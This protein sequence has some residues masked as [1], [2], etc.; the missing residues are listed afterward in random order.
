MG[1]LPLKLGEW[2][3]DPKTLYNECKLCGAR[4]DVMMREWNWD[5]KNK[6]W[7]PRKRHLPDCKHFA[8][9]RDKTPE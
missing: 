3:N 1:N 5:A 6:C 4:G 8:E 9:V 2:C 7:D